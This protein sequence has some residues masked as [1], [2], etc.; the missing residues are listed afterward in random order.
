MS[1]PRLD[2]DMI[3]KKFLAHGLVPRI[4]DRADGTRIVTGIPIEKVDS[5]F[6]PAANL[7]RLMDEQLG[8]GLGD[9][10]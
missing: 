4:E 9:R 3:C 2:L 1:R 10:A 5:V 8:A 7:D 6:D